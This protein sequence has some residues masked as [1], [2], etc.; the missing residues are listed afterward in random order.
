[1]FAPAPGGAPPLEKQYVC[2]LVPVL[3]A[4]VIRPV[5]D[6]A[7][8]IADIGSNKC[9]VTVSLHDMDTSETTSFR[10]CQV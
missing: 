7:T 5:Q 3:P 2:T 6:F 8:D 10:A 1:M 4:A 9:R